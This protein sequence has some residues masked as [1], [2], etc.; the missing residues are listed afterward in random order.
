MEITLDEVDW[1]ILS[2]LQPNARITNVEMARQLEMAP[3][4]VLERVKKLEQKMI[5]KG[6]T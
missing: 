3:S 4:A 5:I 6:Y 2:L 1:K